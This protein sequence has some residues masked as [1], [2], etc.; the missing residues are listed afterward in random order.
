MRYTL[1]FLLVTISYNLQAMEYLFPRQ[2]VYHTENCDNNFSDQNIFSAL[3]N[4][5]KF[6]IKEISHQLIFSTDPTFNNP[7]KNIYSLNLNKI[8]QP[9]F[10]QSIE[11]SSQLLRVVKMTDFV[12]KDWTNYEPIYGL[13]YEEFKFSRHSDESLLY[14]FYAETIVYEGLATVPNYRQKGSCLLTI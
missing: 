1:Y 3:P 13:Y 12:D 4:N 7:K 11:N 6:Y 8:E 5:S 2:V 10:H 14:E 9:G